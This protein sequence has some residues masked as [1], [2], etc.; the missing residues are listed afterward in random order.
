MSHY[1]AL[2]VSVWACAR[3][4]MA[5]G[6]L[7]PLEQASSRHISTMFSS[8]RPGRYLGQERTGFDGEALAHVKQRVWC[9]LRAIGS[10]HGTGQQRRQEVGSALGRSGQRG[11]FL[12]GSWL[13]NA[14]S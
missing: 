7:E 14:P 10:G 13:L 11:Q 3:C 8:R 6:A 2:A 1:K 5:K 4:G 9:M 12:A